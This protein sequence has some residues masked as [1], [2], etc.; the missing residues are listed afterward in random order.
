MQITLRPLGIFWSHASDGSTG[1]LPTLSPNPFDSMTPQ[2]PDQPIEPTLDGE[3]VLG[4]ARAEA[5]RRGWTAPAGA[6]FYADG[7][8]LY[9]VGFFAPGDD[10]G[11]GGL[12]VPWLY[13]DGHSG[14]RVRRSA[15]DGATT[16]SDGR[17]IFLT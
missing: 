13:L 15:D 5:T 1:P 12:G 8:G 6:I 2:P 3:A 7:Y 16:R 9:G 10:H 4:L 14:R 17:F 11:N